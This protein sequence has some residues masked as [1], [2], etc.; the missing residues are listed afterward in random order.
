M[1]LNAWN[2]S[3]GEVEIHKAGCSHHLTTGRRSGATQ[4]IAQDQVEFGKVDW[5]TKYDFAHDYWD[6]GILEEN[7]AENGP[8]SFD[9]FQEMDFKPCTKVLPV[10]GPEV[11]PAPVKPAKKTSAARKAAT[12]RRTPDLRDEAAKA[13]TANETEYVEWTLKVTGCQLTGQDLEI[14]KAGILIGRRMRTFWQEAGR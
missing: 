2:M 11:A 8:G 10:G 3:S 13:L 6:N 9:V 5:A 1:Y 7:E 12:G 14:Y 4:N